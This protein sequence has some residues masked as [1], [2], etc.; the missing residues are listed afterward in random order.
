MRAIAP[1]GER[2]DAFEQEAAVRFGRLEEAFRELTARTSVVV[3]AIM[4]LQNEVSGLVNRVNALARDITTGRTR[5]INRIDLLERRIEAL[6]EQL[7]A[8]K[9]G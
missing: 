5:D 1:L 8:I 3:E 4:G 2:L 9:S 7:R 6:E